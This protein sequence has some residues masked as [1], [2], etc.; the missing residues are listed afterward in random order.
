MHLT[1]H[2][3]RIYK[4]SP[5]ALTTVQAIGRNKIKSAIRALMQ[6]SHRLFSTKTEKEKK[7]LQLDFL[8]ESH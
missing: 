4:G 8:R 5:L 1:P 7:E 6:N 2:C 3:V